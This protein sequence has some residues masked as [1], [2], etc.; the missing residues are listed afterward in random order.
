MVAQFF[1]AIVTFGLYIVYWYYATCREMVAYL[2]KEDSENVFLW[3]LFFG[4]PILFFYSYYKQGV[5]FEEISGKEVNRWIFF[6]LWVVFPPAI[7]ILVQPKLNQLADRAVI[8]TP[9]NLP[10]QSQEPKIN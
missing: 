10:A 5:L 7:W 9:P 2:K 1:L 3:T 8:Q 6:L 4:F